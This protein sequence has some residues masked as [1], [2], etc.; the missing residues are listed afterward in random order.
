MNQ[1]RLESRLWLIQRG[2]ALALVP[3]LA[4]HLAGM[5]LAVRGGLSAA[6]IL[7][8]TRDNTTLAAAYA[9]AVVLASLHGAL[10][11]RNFLAEAL[12][13]RGKALNGSAALAAL[14]LTLWGGR[15]IWSL[16]HASA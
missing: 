16:F 4:L 15:A 12:G 13:W 10:G 2:S 3:L 5:I 1:S 11:L 14:L 8:R 6:E 7:E 9:S